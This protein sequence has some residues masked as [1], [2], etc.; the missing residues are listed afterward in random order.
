M[1]ICYWN[2]CCRTNHFPMHMN[3]W[4][5]AARLSTIS[6]TWINMVMANGKRRRPMQQNRLVFSMCRIVSGHHHVSRTINWIRQ[7]SLRLDR[8]SMHGQRLPIAL[9]TTYTTT[10]WMR[11]MA[12][13]TKIRCGIRKSINWC[14]SYHCPR[15]EYSDVCEYALR[16]TTPHPSPQ[17]ARA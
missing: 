6:N 9:E 3:S 4:I 10:D 8:E 14:R 17:R 12:R 2:N 13:Q 1:W 15:F 5:I 11:C 7:R 16:T